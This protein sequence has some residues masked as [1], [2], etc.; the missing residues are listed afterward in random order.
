MQVVAGEDLVNRDVPERRDV[1]VAQVLDLPLAR[2]RRIGV[3]QVVHGA[4]RARLERARRPHAG[5]R[6]AEELRRRRDFDRRVLGQRHDRV[7]LQER[8]QL[9]QLLA[10]GGEQLARL[11]MRFLLRL[12]PRLDRIAAVEPAGERAELLLR[13]AQLALGDR[14]Q[15]IDRQRNPLVEPQLLLEASRARGGTSPWPSGGRR[16]RGTRR[17]RRSTAPLRWTRRR[18][19]R[20][21]ADRRGCGTR[22]ADRCR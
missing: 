8:L 12:A 21:G 16:F 17:T 3:G 20:A 15:P 7:A 13:L 18:D 2:P 19:R 10:R 14:E 1:E 4:R 22:A 5:E 6:P 11:G 9:A